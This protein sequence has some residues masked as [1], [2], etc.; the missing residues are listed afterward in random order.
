MMAG[1]AEGKSLEDATKPLTST[2]VD[3]PLPTAPVTIPA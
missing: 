3:E 1:L 2:A